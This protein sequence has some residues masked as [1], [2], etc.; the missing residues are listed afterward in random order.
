MPT[1][2]LGSMLSTALAGPAGS[3]DLRGLEAARRSLSDK[4]AEDV[5]AIAQAERDQLAR[6]I[7]DIERAAA[8][9]RRIEPGLETW[10]MTPP[11]RVHKPR[12]LWL[13]IGAL[14][15]ST[16]LATA[17]AVVVIAVLTG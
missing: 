11:A 13:I 14:W 6:D 15:L 1:Q 16:A 12:P 3:I 8:V 2:D 17:G 4:H 7:A 5:D 9:L 10:T